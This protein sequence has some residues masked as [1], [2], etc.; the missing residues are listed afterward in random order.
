MVDNY[1]SAKHFTEHPNAAPLFI[2]FNSEN[3]C[4]SNK[5]RNDVQVSVNC[6]KEATPYSKLES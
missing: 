4:F 1:L 3:L 2:H 5:K 6:K